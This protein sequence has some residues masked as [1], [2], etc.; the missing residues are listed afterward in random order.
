M[1]MRTM[2]RILEKVRALVLLSQCLYF[3]HPAINH[4]LIRIYKVSGMLHLHSKEPLFTRFIS[5][6]G[7]S[8]M[9]RPLP[10]SV[11]EFAYASVLKALDIENLSGPERVKFL[12][13][14]PIEKL[15]ESIPPS[16]PLMP[17]IDGDLIPAVGTLS[18][19][20]NKTNDPTWPMP[21][22]QW[23]KSLMTGDCQFDV[24]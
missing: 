20:S 12:L 9:L 22:R 10:P 6:S 16:I 11:A 13:E 2:L 23:C 15:I 19:I 1:A 8:L 17:V 3:F 4:Q 24:S 18:Q 21:G 7:S 5:M 14:S